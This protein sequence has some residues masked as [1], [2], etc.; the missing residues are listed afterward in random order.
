VFNGDIRKLAW[1]KRTY[2]SNNTQSL[3]QH[4]LAMLHENQQNTT[5]I[6]PEVQD[7]LKTLTQNIG[8]KSAKEDPNSLGKSNNL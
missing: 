3:Q 4:N 6:T 2:Q 8:N 5:E 7:K 1:N